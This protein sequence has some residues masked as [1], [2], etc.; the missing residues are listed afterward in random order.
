MDEVPSPK[1]SVF[2]LGA[3]DWGLGTGDWLRDPTEA[4][5]ALVVGDQGAMQFGLIE[6][7]PESGRRIILG[8]GSLPD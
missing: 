8:V 2:V 6:V 1:S 3:G 7:G 4:A 5:L